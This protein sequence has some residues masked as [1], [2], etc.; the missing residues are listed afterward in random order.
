L[1]RGRTHITG[2]PKHRNFLTRTQGKAT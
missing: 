1:V 2:G